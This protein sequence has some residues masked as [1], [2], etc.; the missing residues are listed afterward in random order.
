MIKSMRRVAAALCCLS[1]GACSTMGVDFSDWA[2][3]YGKAVEK[4]QNENLLLNMVRSA[5]N[6]PLY[7]TT[8][9]VVRGNGSVTPGA[10]WSATYGA[11]GA[12]AP[13][14]FNWMSSGVGQVASSVT[15]GA[16]LSISAG[17]SFD[18]ASLDN[19][20]FV[21]GLLTPIT[22]NT[23]HFYVTQGIPRELLFH[24]FIE[25]IEIAGKGGTTL[26]VNDPLHKS[27]NQFVET[28][29]AFLNLGMTTEN[30]TIQIPVG[31]TLTQQMVGQALPSLVQGAGA[32]FQLAP[33][34]RDSGTEYQIQRVIN[35]A[36]F[37]FKRE[38]GN[39]AI[40]GDGAFCG[41]SATRKEVGE[42]D[43]HTFDYDGASLSIVIRSTRDVFNYL[44][45]QIYN[46]TERKR[47]EPFVLRT[48]EARDYNYLGHGDQLL[49]VRKNQSASNDLV[50]V[51]YRGETYSV[52]AGTEGHSALLFTIM[53]QLVTLSKAVNLIPAST[54]V[55]VR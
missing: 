12:Y 19:A 5:Y 36:R 47:A 46:Q 8:I 4:S 18:M 9:P 42:A 41:G 33:V 6:Q 51:E 11:V 35:T 24:L 2:S 48:T 7:F 45:N 29:E 52:P 23:V 39:E 3:A 26:L 49:V 15:P 50:R 10:T 13:K 55:L 31:P 27:Y 20:E 21:T 25:R 54:P 38:P 34:K 40:L 1:L 22:P 43:A 16:S 44:G 14:A 37:C 32:G 53:A 28:L 17:F 30:K